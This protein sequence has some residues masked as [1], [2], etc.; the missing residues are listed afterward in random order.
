LIR[1]QPVADLVRRALAL[2]R[3]NIELRIDAARWDDGLTTAE[4]LTALR[5]AAHLDDILEKGEPKHL[6]AAQR[7]WVDQQIAAYEHTMTAPTSQR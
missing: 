7:Q 6:P 5:E 4:R 3:T 1:H 2:D